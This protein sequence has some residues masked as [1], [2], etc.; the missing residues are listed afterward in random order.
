MMGP[1]TEY[2]CLCFAFRINEKTKNFD[3]WS[4]F[5]TTEIH[6]ESLIIPFEKAFLIVEI[7]QEAQSS[8]LNVYNLFWRVS[9]NFWLKW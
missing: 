8:R 1:N 7:T 6:Y 5:W 2:F 9:F 4:P 3:L